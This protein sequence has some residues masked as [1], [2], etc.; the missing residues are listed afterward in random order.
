[1]TQKIE[2]S[3]LVSQLAR[4]GQDILNELTPH[5]VAV[6]HAAIGIAGEAGELLDAIKKAYLYGQPVNMQNVIEELGDI[7]FY[8]E[9]FRQQ[10]EIGKGEPIR[11]NIEK[12]Q[13]RYASGSF[14]TAE[15]I[16]RVDKE[17]V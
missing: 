9:A 16:A 2:H 3:I 17:S 12:L 7:E 5:K 14:T 11:A 10:M 13:K 1:M 6:L 8:L 15:S 4:P